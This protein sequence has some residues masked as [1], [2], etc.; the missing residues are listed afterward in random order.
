MKIYY[1]TTLIA[2]FLLL[3]V[4]GVKAQ[5]VPE[6]N[7]LMHALKAGDHANALIV[8]P[9]VEDVDY[10][11]ESGMSLLMYSAGLGYSD[12][13]KILLDNGAKVNI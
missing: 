10:K 9:D 4:N 8:V 6:A 7:K 12:V 5:A 2:L 3:L 11:D 1:K 13:C